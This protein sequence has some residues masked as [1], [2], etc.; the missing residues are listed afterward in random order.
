MLK[1]IAEA[2]SMLLKMA[3]GVSNFAFARTSG[4]IHEIKVTA[5]TWFLSFSVSYYPR[6][7]NIMAH[8]LVARGCMCSPNVD[9]FLDGVP[10]GMESLVAGGLTA[11]ITL[12]GFGLDATIFFRQHSSFIAIHRVIVTFFIFWL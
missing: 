11:P 12:Q 8:D 6:S 5:L 10:V 3:I 9:L 2:D 4:L 1:V 7:C